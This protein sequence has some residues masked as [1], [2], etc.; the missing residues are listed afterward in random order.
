MYVSQ[1]K[2]ACISYSIVGELGSSSREGRYVVVFNKTI[3]GHRYLF[4]SQKYKFQF[5]I[6]NSPLVVVDLTYIRKQET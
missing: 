2:F 4:D 3:F 5:K 6:M 1:S